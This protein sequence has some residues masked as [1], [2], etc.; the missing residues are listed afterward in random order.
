M[1]KP[2]DLG[3]SSERCRKA[4]TLCL[5][6]RL[7]RRG[8]PTVW[9]PS[10]IPSR[11]LKMRLERMSDSRVEYPSIYYE[12]CEEGFD[13]RH[14]HRLVRVQGPQGREHP[15]QFPAGSVIRKGARFESRHPHPIHTVQP[16]HGV[17]SPRS[18]NDSPRRKTPV[19]GSRFLPGLEEI[20]SSSRV[21][22]H[23]VSFSGFSGLN[24]L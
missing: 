22:R 19:A 2:Y 23:L 5:L 3:S 13:S 10:G 16:K 6:D 21:E 9:I 24:N 17:S 18:G 7:A 12:R 1:T 4:K 11:S 20:R 15:V 14:L 8:I